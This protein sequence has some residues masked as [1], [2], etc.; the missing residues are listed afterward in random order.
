MEGERRLQRISKDVVEI[1]MR[2]AI[3][4][5]EAIWMHHDKGPEL[6]G[7]RGKTG[8]ISDRIV[9]GRRPLVRI[10]TPFEFEMRHD[11]VEFAH[12]EFGLLQRDH[13]EADKPIRLAR[14]KFG[15]A[16]IGEAMRGLRDFGVDG[17]SS[18]APAPER[19]PG[20]R[21]PWRPCRA[22]ADRSS[23]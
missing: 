21:R 17:C 8:G 20:C 9:P 15:D 16:V 19:P 22:G 1:K 3:A 6:F 5:S 2:Q 12:R 23:S 4:M 7:L 11:V 13:P 18:T 14:A 10:S